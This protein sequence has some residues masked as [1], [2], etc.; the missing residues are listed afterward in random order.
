M[1]DR[2]GVWKQLIEWQEMAPELNSV[3][4]DLA[5]RGAMIVHG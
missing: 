5:G 1:W 3:V 2:H 4:G